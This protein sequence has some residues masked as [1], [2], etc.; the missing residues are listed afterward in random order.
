MFVTLKRYVCM[1]GGGGLLNDC[2]NLIFM[3]GKCHTHAHKVMSISNFLYLAY[4]CAMESLMGYKFSTESVDVSSTSTG[5]LQSCIN[6]C[7][8]DTN[9]KS[10]SYDNDNTR[11]H[12]H[13]QISVPVEDLGFDYVVRRCPDQEDDSG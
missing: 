11:C 4:S 9:C 8:D 13:D 3:C 10:F 6:S 1:W 7:L 5:T 12:Y 2:K